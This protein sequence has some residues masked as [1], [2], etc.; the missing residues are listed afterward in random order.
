[1]MMVVFMLVIMIMLVVMII[2]L[3]ASLAIY[4]FGDLFGGAQEKKA[5]IDLNSLKVA[6]V[7]YRGNTGSYPTTEQG[8]QALMV[9]REPSDL[10][11]HRAVMIK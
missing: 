8:L 11:D 5:K 7:A 4:N 3:L 6:L 1:M 9:E 2:A 10:S